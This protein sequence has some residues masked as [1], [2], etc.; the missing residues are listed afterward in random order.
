MPSAQIDHFLLGCRD[1][2]T[3]IDRVEQLTGVRAQVG[4]NTRD[5]APIMH[6]CR[7]ASAAT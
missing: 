4:G 6:F 5:A 2:E 3:G 7:L 1:L